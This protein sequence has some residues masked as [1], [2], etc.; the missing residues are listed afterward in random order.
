[1]G[2]PLA[3][4]LVTTFTYGFATAAILIPA[5]S[6]FVVATGRTTGGEEA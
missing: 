1:L 6:E 4:I 2:S 3:V 5:V